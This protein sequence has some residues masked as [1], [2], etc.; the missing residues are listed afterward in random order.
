MNGVGCGGEPWGPAEGVARRFE[1]SREFLGVG[2]PM[3]GVGCGGEPWGPVSLWP[4][5]APSCSVTHK[6]EPCPHLQAQ[7]RREALGASSRVRS[8]LP[9]AIPP[10]G[11]L[12]AQNTQRHRPVI[13]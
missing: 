10:P 1:G 7:G 13:Q 5:S 8:C 6:P 11:M 12:P 4:S 2:V 9:S 3:N